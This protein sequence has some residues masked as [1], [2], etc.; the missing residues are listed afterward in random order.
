[1]TTVLA[2]KTDLDVYKIGV[3]TIFKNKNDSGNKSKVFQPLL[4]G[5]IFTFL[6]VYCQN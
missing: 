4:E 6:E 5:R 3:E 1:M 2:Q